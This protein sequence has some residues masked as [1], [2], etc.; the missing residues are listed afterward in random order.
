MNTLGFAKVLVLVITVTAARGVAVGQSA[1]RCSDPP[2][3]AHF[4][5]VAPCVRGRVV[6]VR[7]MNGQSITG[8]AVATVVK[9]SSSSLDEILTLQ[10]PKGTNVVKVP[11]I[12]DLTY[13]PPH[14][15]RKKRLYRVLGA[16]AGAGL[17]ACGLALGV[18]PV[19]ALVPG[20]GVGLLSGEA[21]LQLAR[22][23]PAVVRLAK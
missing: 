8:T 15:A 20:L 19:I 18:A 14:A 9:P 23:S 22:N 16:V 4:R 5:D 17:F 11:E 12:E 3:F 21:A 10:T 6:T 7:L 2:P 1:D 13:R